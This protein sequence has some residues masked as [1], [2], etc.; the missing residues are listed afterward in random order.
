MT[1]TLQQIDL[2]AEAVISRLREHPD[3]NV[4]TFDAPMGA[5]K[6]TLIAAICRKLGVETDDISSPTFSIINEYRADATGRQIYHF[7]CYRLDD[8]NEALDMGVEEYFD[9]G[10]LCLIEWPDII[11]PLL[12]SRTLTV[13][14]TPQS[15]TLRELTLK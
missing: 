14:L 11:A 6:T 10:A 13:T 4:V 9:S 5:G 1:F 12:P 15:D 3:I 2:A 7:D 8:I